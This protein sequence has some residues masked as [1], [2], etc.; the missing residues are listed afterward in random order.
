MDQLLAKPTIIH[1]LFIDGVST[2][3]SGGVIGMTICPGKKDNGYFSG[4]WERNLDADLQAIKDWGAVALVS[5]IEG[6]EFRFLQVQDLPEK[7]G[8]F[9]LRWM[10]L[11][12]PEASIPDQSFEEIWH[13]AGPQLRQWLKEGK[14]IVLH[15]NEGFGRTGIIAARLLVEL[16]VELDDAIHSTRKAR[17]GAIVNVLQEKYVRQCKPSEA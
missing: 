3:D 16:G 7:A 12:I 9:G 14:K 17:S 15:C 1:P 4:F 2:P 11:P 8:I 13:E 10:H 5:L 6:F